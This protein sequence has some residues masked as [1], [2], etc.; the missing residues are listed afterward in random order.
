MYSIF[1]V[2]RF[3]EVVS[4]KPKPTVSGEEDWRAEWEGKR[5]GFEENGESYWRVGHREC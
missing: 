5:I 1:I 4:G 3:V 2:L